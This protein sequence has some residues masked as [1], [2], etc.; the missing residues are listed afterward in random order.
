MFCRHCGKTVEKAFIYCPTCGKKCKKRTNLNQ[1]GQFNWFIRSAN[2]KS[3]KF[4]GILQAK[5]GGKEFKIC[6]KVE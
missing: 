6:T 2:S 5:R 4:Q 3:A 1:S